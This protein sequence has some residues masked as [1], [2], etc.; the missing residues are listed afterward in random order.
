MHITY[1][2]ISK[3]RLICDNILEEIEKEN[4]KKYVSIYRNDLAKFTEDIF[5][6]KLKLYQKI[7]LNSKILLN[8]IIPGRNSNMRYYYYNLYNLMIKYM[9]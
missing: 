9:K 6:I 2:F 8:N 1:D 5:G 4:I 7:L 3:Y